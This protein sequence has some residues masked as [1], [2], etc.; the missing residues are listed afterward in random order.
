MS[1]AA[2]IS[3]LLS[4]K[5]LSAVGVSRATWFR[6]TPWPGGVTSLPVVGGR[7]LW[8]TAP[9]EPGHLLVV[10]QPNYFGRFERRAPTGENAV[11]VRRW[12][13]IEGNPGSV[14]I[15]LQ[16]DVGSADSAKNLAGRLRQI[17]GI[18]LA[19]GQPESPWFI[20]NLPGHPERVA[21]GLA[22][23]GCGGCVPL[24]TRFP[25]FP[26]GLRIEVAWPESDNERFARTVR[27][28]LE[29]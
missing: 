26:G 17:P 15:E 23:I 29:L 4:V 12:G 3:E 13:K 27:T 18:G 14:V 19:H 6:D 10:E 21:A 16:T 25:E 24:G 22:N 1:A 5:H 28:V 9:R 2:E 20:V 7:T 11:T 8:E